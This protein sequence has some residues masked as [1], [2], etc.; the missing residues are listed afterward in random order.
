MPPL[1]KLGQNYLPHLEAIAQICLM[2]V[3]VL[4]FLKI[5]NNPVPGSELLKP[6]EFPEMRAEGVSC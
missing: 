2:N 5:T 4:M 3:N 1:R 6:L